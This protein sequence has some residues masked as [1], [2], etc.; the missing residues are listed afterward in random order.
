MQE[1]TSPFHPFFLE[2]LG[3][4]QINISVNSYQLPH[5][6]CCFFVSVDP[7]NLISWP[8]SVLVSVAV[9]SS[10]TIKKSV[11]ADQ[12]MQGDAKYLKFFICFFLNTAGVLLLGEKRY[13]LILQVFRLL[14]V[15]PWGPSKVPFFTCNRTKFIGVELKGIG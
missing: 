1:I 2:D 15:S 9:F 4:T 5:L 10:E 8:K 13:N 12:K 11:N 6:L 3:Y 14:H 7:R